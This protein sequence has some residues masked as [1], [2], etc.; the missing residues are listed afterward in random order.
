MIALPS[1]M[2]RGPALLAVI[3]LVGGLFVAPAVAGNGPKCRVTSLATNATSATLQAGVDAASDGDTLEVKG[4]CGGNTVIDRSVVIDG[5]GKSVLDGQGSGPVVIV[6]AGVSVT[7]VDLDIVNGSAEAGAGLMNNG[8][9]VTIIDSIIRSNQAGSRGGGLANNSGSMT[10]VDTTV[11]DNSSAGTG[12][13][14][15]NGLLG[16]TL[17]LE[18]GTTIRDNRA[19]GQGGGIYEE[20]FGMLFLD[21]ASAIWGNAAVGDGG[22]VYCA[23]SS[24]Q[25]N[26]ASSIRGNSAGGDGGGVFISGFCP[27]QLNEASTIDSNVATNGAGVSAV[28]G[29]VVV[30]GTSSISNNVA[31]ADGGGVALA[32]SA[33]V[34]LMT[35]RAPSTATGQVTRAAASSATRRVSCCSWRTEGSTRI[36]RAATAA[37][38]L[39]APSR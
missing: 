22:G 21:D 11:S 15:D 12:G 5:K 17:I 36:L 9:M 39:A 10:L 16:G 34:T 20:H 29:S 38:C 25:L 28:L 30:A 13:G 6:A 2:R 14:I 1:V 8:G 4:V 18:G 19:A 24:V 3:V 27:L 7:I 35:D 23:D 33:S 31:A 37:A 26:S 32:L